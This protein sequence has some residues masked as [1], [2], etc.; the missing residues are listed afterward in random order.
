MAVVR[1]TTLAVLSLAVVFQYSYT[2]GQSTEVFQ[3]NSSNFIA[4]DVIVKF[5]SDSEAADIVAQAVRGKLEEDPRL[6]AYIRELGTTLSTPISTRQITSGGE[7]ILRLDIQKLI[8]QFVVSIQENEEVARVD[9]VGQS[10][11]TNVPSLRIYFESGGAGARI[12]NDARQSGLRN[13]ID[14]LVA[15]FH[16]E[17]DLMLS[18][19]VGSEHD[20]LVEI[21]PWQVTEA[22]ATRL[23]ELNEVEYSELNQLM[24]FRN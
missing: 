24:N 20:L 11:P 21:D 12:I 22:L 7:V 3:T 2:F 19:E 14:E 1:C 9:V 8:N 23:N 4:S 17:H 13:G 6:K 15:K 5:R 18:Y 10:S 16:Q